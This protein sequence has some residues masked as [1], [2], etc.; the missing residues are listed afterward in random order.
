[1]QPVPAEPLG[2]KKSS[3]T[4]R[5]VRIP[6]G[7]FDDKTI[8]SVS[9]HSSSEAEHTYLRNLIKRQRIAGFASMFAGLGFGLVVTLAAV[10]WAAAGASRDQLEVQTADD[11]RVLEAGH[12]PYVGYAQDMT[13]ELASKSAGVTQQAFADGYDDWPPFVLST[14]KQKVRSNGTLRHLT[15]FSPLKMPEFSREFTED[16]GEPTFVMLVN[17]KNRREYAF[18]VCDFDEKYHFTIMVTE[19]L[20]YRFVNHQATNKDATVAEQVVYAAPLGKEDKDRFV[21]HGAQHAAMLE[22]LSQ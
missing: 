7:M 17:T 9:V 1:M 21:L 20:T 6:T 10:K 19:V 13:M 8:D 22:T 16:G 15:K 2:L 5:S 18:R 4:K 11:E 14:F 3:K 12:V